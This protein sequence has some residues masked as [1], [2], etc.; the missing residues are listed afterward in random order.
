MY[1]LIEIDEEGRANVV[2]DPGNLELKPAPTGLEGGWPYAR[3]VRRS[4]RDQAISVYV[5]GRSTAIN[6]VAFNPATEELDITFKNGTSRQ[7]YGTKPRTYRY[8]NVP[9][10]QLMR[11]L[12]ADSL[13]AFFNSYVRNQYRNQQVA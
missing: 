2:R 11:L 4:T 6:T 1:Y 3:Q 8:S 13:G 12:V 9:L 10:S 7:P 5:G